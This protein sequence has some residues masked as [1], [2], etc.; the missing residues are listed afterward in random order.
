ML[1]LPLILIIVIIIYGPQ[2]WAGSILNRYNREEYFSG[3]GLELARMLLDEQGLKDVTVEETA[4][5]DHYTPQT[6]V[7]GLTAARCGRRSCRP[8]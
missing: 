6:K 8:T 2:M 7:V 1:Y 5:G 3:N 4:I